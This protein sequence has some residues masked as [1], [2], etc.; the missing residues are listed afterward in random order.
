V[1]DNFQNSLLKAIDTLASYRID[2]MDADK[3]VVATIVQC[4]NALTGEYLVKCDG[5]NMKAYA[6]G[7]A[8]YSQDETVY[9]L[10]PKG[11]YTQKKMILSTM[12]SGGSDNL[13]FVTSVANDYNIIG[14]DVISKNGA[15]PVGLNSY[16]KEDMI[17]LY[18]Y[19]TDP[20]DGSPELIVNNEDLSAYIKQAQAILVQAD[21]RT[22][23]PREH[24][25]TTTGDYGIQIV[26]AFAGKDNPEEVTYTSYVLNVTS[27][28]G[29]PY[30]YNNFTTQ[31]ALFEVDAERFLYVDSIIAFSNNFVLEDDAVAAD[32]WGDDIFVDNIQV[33]GLQEI[34][35]TSGDYMLKLSMPQGGIF[36]ISGNQTPEDV[37]LSVLAR[38]TYKVTQDL[39]Q[40]T[41]FYWG[42]EDM[43]VDSLSEYYNAYLG[44]GWRYMT[45]RG[46]NQDMSTNAAE[47][48]AHENKWICCAVYQEQ[49]VLKQEFTLI[50]QSAANN[51]KIE[52][53]LGTKFS[54][55]RGEPILTCYV[56]DKASD[57]DPPDYSDDDFR[58]VWARVDATSGTIILDRS[59]EDIQ[60][61]IDD[62]LDGGNYS[63]KE[64]AALKNKLSQV[65]NVEFMGNRRNIIKY[66]VGNITTSAT[67]KCSVYRKRSDNK[68]VEDNIGTA[69][70]TL[71]NE[72]AADASQYYILIENGDQVFQYSESGVSPASDRYTDPLEIKELVCHFYDQTHLEVN[73]DMYDL[74]WK[75]PTS[76]TMLVRPTEN[77]IPNEANDGALEYY[78]GGPQRPYPLDIV[79]NYDYQALNNQITAIVTYDGQQ[80]S[81]DTNFL[82]VKVGDNGTNGTDVV[83]KIVLLNNKAEVEDVTF[84]TSADQD[85]WGV[86]E[87]LACLESRDGAVKWNLS[88][89]W[90]N[91][92]TI[93]SVALNMK[94]YRRNEYIADT[95]TRWQIA[96][97]NTHC[98]NLAIGKD[99]GVL[100]W[101]TVEKPVNPR[102]DNQIARGQVTLDNQDYYCFYPVVFS[103]Y[104]TGAPR[105]YL[106]KYK[107]LKFVTYNADGHVP[108]YNKNQGVFFAKMPQDFTATFSVQGGVENDETT[109]AIKILAYNNNADTSPT[110]QPIKIEG[111]AGDMPGVYV[112]PDDI[113][114]GATTNHNVIVDIKYDDDTTAKFIVPICLS[115]N[116]FGLASLNAWDGQHVEINEDENY[117]LAPQVGAGMKDDNNRFTGI[118]MGKMETYNQDEP[119]VNVGMLG[120]SKGKQSIWLDAQTGNAIFG[121][122]EK[123]ASTDTQWQEGRIELIPGGESKI[124]MWRIGSHNLY[125]LQYVDQKGN[126]RGP[127]TVADDDPNNWENDWY[128]EGDLEKGRDDFPYRG[129]VPAPEGAQFSIPHAFGTG[130]ILGSNPSYLSVKGKPLGDDDGLSWDSANQ[131]FFRGDSLE[132]EIDANSKNIFTIYRH[133]NKRRNPETNKIDIVPWYRTPMVGINAEGK[134]YTNSLKDGESSM[135]IG[136]VGAFGQAA[137]IHEFVGATFAYGTDNNILKFFQHANDD[138]TTYFSA[139][140]YTSGDR[141]N[142]YNRHFK[143]YATSFSLYADSSKNIT[144]KSDAYLTLTEGLQG[145]FVVNQTKDAEAGT[146]SHIKMPVDG[147]FSLQSY[148]GPI[149]LTATGSDNDIKLTGK[150]ILETASESYTLT[151]DKNVS[152]T[153]T[154]GNILATVSSDNRSF[155]VSQGTFGNNITLDQDKFFSGTNDNHVR[156]N[157]SSSDNKTVSELL[158][159]SPILLQSKTMDIDLKTMGASRQIRLSTYSS[160]SAE[161]GDYSARIALTSAGDG[162][163]R[164]DMSAGG[165]ASLQLKT[166]TASD[167]SDVNGKAGVQIAPLL[168]A[169]SQVITGNT[170]FA[171]GTYGLIVQE[172]ALFRS[173]LKVNGAIDIDGT[174]HVAGQDQNGYGVWADYKIGSN[175]ELTAP[176]LR[177]STSLQVG[178]K[179]MTQS[180]FDGIQNLYNHWRPDTNGGYFPLGATEVKKIM[181]GYGVAYASQIPSSYTDQNVINVINT[182]GFWGTQTIIDYCTRLNRDLASLQNRVAALER[183]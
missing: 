94:L 116:T 45:E 3:T 65:Q 95:K 9:V 124:G 19:D 97:G 49:V 109:S 160:L 93:S 64:Y 89:D 157:V 153:A 147:E 173:N 108:L 105:A 177:G 5:G 90:A 68:D 167:G 50:N 161:D 168:V 37:V 31:Q 170:K 57:F 2:Q 4:T 92:P 115:L 70:I 149:T 182:H 32:Q 100:S 24:R 172:L 26:C 79:D 111:K 96:G 141:A 22:A 46:N 126:T 158:V 180:W 72:S 55:D 121:L 43:E 56:N 60:A 175:V 166:F 129:D 67:F 35:A 156:I 38:V 30:Q 176:K 174:L 84:T 39:S 151:A 77:V 114:S 7:E 8:T 91:C 61:A 154:K 20:P 155:K 29:N 130:I 131:E 163:S 159:N 98:T 83:A 102:Y 178:N 12:S 71:V 51:V 123:Q 145:E 16:Y 18:L 150:N 63:Y 125:N 148:G 78:Q 54:F 87:A 137:N 134:F 101:G 104:S 25:K 15:L 128:S 80:F 21:F 28:V 164:I 106:D 120:F 113:Y 14:G 165:G 171:D 179:D 132:A 69:E 86:Q 36:K 117:V 13:T 112:Y 107:T 181:D 85:K 139:G 142:E 99:D 11:D 127:L 1:A 59:A 66:P 88:Q 6:Q 136:F 47:N 33:Y 82:F 143:F 74:V 169:Q 118:L 81:Q 42:K 183:G 133:T 40:D 53:N 52:S 103:E 162:A 146:G 58:F 48:V 73:P 41:T 135:G 75:F 44:S 27:M 138:S 122:P 34:A 144:E 152:L 62:L 10:V 23:L 76:S 110:N 119:I 140:S 17:P